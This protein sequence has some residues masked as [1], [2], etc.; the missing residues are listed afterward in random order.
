MGEDTY[1][2]TMHAGDP[3]GGFGPDQ[4]WALVWFVAVLIGGITLTSQLARIDSWMW[5]N[6]AQVLDYRQYAENRETFTSLGTERVDPRARGS[7]S[8]AASEAIEAAV[9]R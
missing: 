2:A 1:E 6:N 9:S 4:R 3:C 5:T 8:T 7:Y